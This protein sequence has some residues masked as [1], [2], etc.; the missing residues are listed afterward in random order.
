M[1][2]FKIYKVPY[3]S[4]G[5]NNLQ[6]LSI[7]SGTPESDSGLP[8]TKKFELVLTDYHV[9]VQ[10]HLLLGCSM[11]LFHSSRGEEHQKQLQD[12]NAESKKSQFQ[13]FR[14][15]KDWHGQLKNWLVRNRLGS[16]SWSCFSQ[17]RS[18]TDWASRSWK[19]VA[20]T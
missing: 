19:R 10:H 9:S 15:L 20:N 3:E 6:L 13:H 14:G 5:Y 2:K 1:Y 16:Y 11:L 18:K 8:H 4:V 17:L 12:E 7:L